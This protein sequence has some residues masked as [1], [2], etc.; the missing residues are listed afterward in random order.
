MRVIV[1]GATGNVGTSVIQALSDSSQVDEA[2]GLARRRPAWSPR[3]TSWVDADV[4][5]P[6]LAELFE[7]ADAVVHLAWAIQPSRDEATLERINV[8][9]SRNVF[10]AAAAAGVPRLVHAS[11]VGAYSP[12]PKDRQVDESWPTDGVQTSFYSR[13][14]AAVERI[15]DDFERRNEAIS[16]ARLRPALIFKGDA[17][18]EIRR[19]FIGPLLPNVLVRPGL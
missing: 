11:S 9:G 14:K 16:V 19:Y 6:S 4:L 12:G 15:L 3:K 17:A 5:D 8:E 10:E 2:V 18:T 13:H 7:G 1:T